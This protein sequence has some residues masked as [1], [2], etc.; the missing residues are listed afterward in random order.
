MLRASILIA[1]LVCIVAT[2]ALKPNLCKK[3]MA[4]TIKSLSID[5]CSDYPCLLKKGKEP[6]INIEFQPRRL[7]K[8]SSV[9]IYGKINNREIPFMSED[10]GHCE[11]SVTDLDG[12]KPTGCALRK[13]KSY[14][15]KFSLPVKSEYPTMSLAVK[16]ELVDAKGASI[17]CFVFPAQIEE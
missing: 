16:Y 7:I 6:S 4:A 11:A 5:D 14:N 3:K 17:F 2:N 15:Y 13:N 10:S 9:R 8:G 12:S 1:F